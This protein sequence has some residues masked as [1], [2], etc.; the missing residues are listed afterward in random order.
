MDI[1][2]TNPND[3]MNQ[4][5]PSLQTQV[6]ASQPSNALGSAFALHQSG[7][8]MGPGKPRWRRLLVAALALLFLNTALSFSTWWP[9]PGIVLDARLAPE[10]VG[11]WVL[12]LA[13]VG[14]RGGLSS[15]ALSGVTAAYGVLVL[16][17]YADVTAPALFGRPINLFWDGWQIPRFFW[18]STQALAWWWSVAAVLAALLL[19]G[20][21]FGLLRWGVRVTARDAV[22]YALRTPWVWACTAAAVVVAAANYAGVQATWPFVSKPVVPMYWRQ[23]TLLVAAFSPQRL[24]TLLPA[25]SAVD[26]AMAQPPGQ[27]LAALRGR[28]VYLLMLESLGAVTYDNPRANALLRPARDRFADE[29]AASGRQVVSAFMTSPTFGGG[30]ELA[31]LGVLSGIDLSDP[32][33]HDVLLTTKRPTLVSLF[34]Q[35]G[36]QTF[37]LYA[38]LAWDW[39]ERA[40]YGFDV[41]IEGRDL[42][43]PGPA[44]G[45]WQIPDQYAVARFEQQHPRSDSAPPRFVFFPTITN[46]LPFSPLPPYQPQWSQLLTSQP[47]P[48]AETQAALA[49]QANWLDMFPGF[50]RLVDYTYRW[51]G[52]WLMQ[53]EPREA[54]Y[55]LVGDHQP[56]ASVSGEGASWDVPVHIISRDPALLQRFVAQGFV[57]GMEP[58]RRTLG[59]LHELTG[60][61]LQA[62]K[63][64][65][66][67]SSHAGLSAPEGLAGADPAVRNR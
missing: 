24:A 28:D 23:A 65:A 33:R 47:F 40:F 10:F 62:F 7:P 16:G 13:L 32:M 15:R 25:A 19:F 38:S 57:P 34:R 12:L 51:L 11:L 58:H 55:V 1:N 27:A 48:V 21:L 56:A 43:Y 22:P 30:S 8:G 66:S 44:L 36:Y 60:M 2:R 3:G 31:Q 4:R 50:V 53:P 9:T 39:P 18:I 37:G 54:V 5:Q 42:Q 64:D 63:G 17:R 49:E 67:K 41:F 35:Q 14:W 26:H 52:G 29:V 61:A 45:Y 59:P 46:H 6:E 20:L